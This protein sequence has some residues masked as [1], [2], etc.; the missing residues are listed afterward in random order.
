MIR[1]YF[2]PTLL[3][4]KQSRAD[5]VS[6]CIED[7]DFFHVIILASSNI[8]FALR[9]NMAAST[10]AFTVTFQQEAEKRKEYSGHS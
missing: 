1:V 10:P 9:S 8:A 3:W 6:H 5:V 4:D 7:L 2:C